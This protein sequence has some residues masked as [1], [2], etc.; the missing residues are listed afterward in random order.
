MV[1]VTGA[2]WHK[3]MNVWHPRRVTANPPQCMH[4][5]AHEVCWGSCDPHK[6][7]H[8]PPLASHPRRLIFIPAFVAR[9]QVQM[10]PSSMVAGAGEGTQAETKL[11]PLR[12]I[13]NLSS[14]SMQLELAWTFDISRNSVILIPTYIIHNNECQTLRLPPFSASLASGVTV[15][16]SPLRAQESVPGM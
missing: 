14:Y 5:R 13:L 2:I 15:F 16:S 1:V 8:I 7:P 9:C 10:T 3:G 12:T 6:I 11:E 4:S